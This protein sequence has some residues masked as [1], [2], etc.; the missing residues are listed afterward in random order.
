M[1]RNTVLI[2]D[3][4]APVRTVLKALLRK[5]FAC[6]EAENGETATHIVAE[7]DV[8]VVVLD[9]HMPGMDGYQVLE[10]IRTRGGPLVADIP[11]IVHTASSERAEVERAL[12]LGANDYIV[13]GM[14]GKDFAMELPLKVKNLAELRRTRANLARAERLSLLSALSTGVAHEINNP[15]TFVH[16][17]MDILRKMFGR[18]W[19]HLNCTS[20]AAAA[21]PGDVVALLREAPALVDDIRRGCERIEAIV[22]SLSGEVA[23]DPRAVGAVCDLGVCAEQALHETAPP[24]EVAVTREIVRGLFFKGSGIQIGQVVRNLIQN[25]IHALA[26]AEHKR[27]RV[28]VYADDDRLLCAVADSG[29]GIDATARDKLFTPLFTTKKR[30]EGTGLG[31]WLCRKI[32]RAHG[33]NLD[34][35][36]PEGWSTEFRFFLPQESARD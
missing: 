22:Q 33:G 11:V 30:G 7:H 26:P 4:S 9:L 27:L 25:A 28:R 34:F 16:G 17:N 36:A 13:K 35:H 23:D 14:P 12:A 29:S 24:P 3:D 5:S 31:L 32:V 21:L 15:L 20:G 18:A 8:D 10:H 6:L 1:D 2:V 19:D